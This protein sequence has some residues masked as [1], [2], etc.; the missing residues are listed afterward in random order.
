MS[1]TAAHRLVRYGA[2][3]FGAT[4][5]V[6]VEWLGH[7]AL[8]LGSGAPVGAVVASVVEEFAGRALSRRQEARIGGV[9]CWA[10]DRISARLLSGDDLRTDE[11]F[12]FD[13]MGFSSCHQL[14]EGTLLKSRDEYEERKLR[15]HALLFANTLFDDTV[16]PQA[17]LMLLKVLE[18]LTYRQLVILAAVA[19]A[20]MLELRAL[21]EPAHDDPDLDALQREEMELHSG[22]IGTCG[23]LAGGPWTDSLSPLG[24][25]LH[26][27]AGLSEID[28][29]EISQL[30]AKIDALK[31]A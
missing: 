24:A 9:V 23:L 4:A 6:A 26:R 12:R 10:A 11:F 7:A 28:T 29:D 27:V 31:R 17:A 21:R 18:R 13:D 5:S 30:V 20:G 19:S 15:H 16:S 2:E 8:P 14:L 22:D 25:T 1:D 3:I